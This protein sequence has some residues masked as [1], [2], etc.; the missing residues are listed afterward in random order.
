MA[1]IHGRL[2]EVFD[3]ENKRMPLSVKLADF[4][5]QLSIV[6]DD[7]AVYLN[8]RTG[9]FVTLSTDDVLGFE[10]E[11][12]FADAEDPAEPDSLEDEPEWLKEEHRI[13]REV[14][15]SDDY[16]AL[17]DQF[18]IHDW[19][20]MKDF[21]GSVKDARLREQLLGL[22]RGRGA[23]GRFNASIKSL[24]I[25]QAW[26][27]FHDRALE[28]IAVE[29]LEQNEIPFE[30]SE[31]QVPI[32]DFEVASQGMSAHGVPAPT[33]VRGGSR[34]MDEDETRK[35]KR[36]AHRQK[37]PPAKI[38]NAGRLET[39]SQTEE[40]KVFISNRNSHCGECNNDLG[41]KA[42]ITLERE[43]GALCLACA[44]G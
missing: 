39:P 24:G 29:W 26:L 35:T 14:L 7:I 25:E 27:Q 36:V 6:S 18:D 15:N 38:D 5:E 17:P 16:L 21:C 40:I 22:I 44:D 23:F 32:A 28:Q 42:W 30:I 10:D 4:V 43:K 41:K 20:I 3:L 31:G 12:D 19:Q 33:T 1:T 2:D 11:N 37:A 13:R 8:K 34:S 9:E